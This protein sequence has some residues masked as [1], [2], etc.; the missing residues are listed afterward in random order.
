MKDQ[1]EDKKL[2]VIVS[3]TGHDDYSGDFSPNSSVASILA[4]AMEEFELEASAADKYGLQQNGVDVPT[5][6]KVEDL[7]PEPI[8]LSLVLLQDQA[9]GLEDADG[10]GY[11]L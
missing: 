2:N 11:L 8:R 4:K 10:F 6:K 1:K 9:K 5:N 7:G 3:Y